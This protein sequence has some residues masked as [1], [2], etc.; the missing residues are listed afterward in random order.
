MTGVRETKEQSSEDIPYIY[1]LYCTPVH[2]KMVGKGSVVQPFLGILAK[3]TCFR[4][5]PAP[6][7]G[8]GSSCKNAIYSFLFV[9]VVIRIKTMI[10][11]QPQLI[12]CVLQRQSK[13]ILKKP[14]NVRGFYRCFIFL[15]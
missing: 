8:S 9:K 4:S 10:F 11:V 2:Y 12:N 1:C 6:A 5:A 3:P 14:V 13:R 7:S 15:G